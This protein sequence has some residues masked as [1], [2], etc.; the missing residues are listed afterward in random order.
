MIS[1]NCIYFTF[2]SLFSGVHMEGNFSETEP[3][4]TKLTR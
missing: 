1:N 4:I 3:E 2:N